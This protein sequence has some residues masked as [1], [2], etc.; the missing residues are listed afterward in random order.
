[1]V[2]YEKLRF[3]VFGKRL[4]VII[5]TINLAYILLVSKNMYSNPTTN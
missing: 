3:L 2:L 4:T 5:I 1:V